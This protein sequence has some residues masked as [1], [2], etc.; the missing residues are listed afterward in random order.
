MLSTG[1]GRAESCLPGLVREVRPGPIRQAVLD[2]VRTL[3]QSQ[4]IWGAFSISCFRSG[5]RSTLICFMKAKTLRPESF[6]TAHSLIHVGVCKHR[7]PL[8]PC[9]SFIDDPEILS[10]YACK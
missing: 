8:S 5:M 9:P 6:L 4:D 7:T 2:S 3:M 1:M 10:T